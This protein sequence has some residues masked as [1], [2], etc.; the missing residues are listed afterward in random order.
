MTTPNG[1]TDPNPANNSA[2]DTSTITF[3]ADLSVTVTDNKQ[4]YTPG[5]NNVYKIVVVNFGPSNVTGASVTDNFPSVFTG[6]TFTAT[7]MGGASG[8]TA[9]GSGNIRDTVT[10]PVGS[11]I[12]YTA[13]GSISPSA[14]GPLSNTATVTVPGGV[15][16]PN[17]ANNSA[18]DTDT[19]Q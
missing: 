9:S 19:Q 12:S 11:R 5:R 15:T 14:R 17:P 18:T 7:Q 16:D 1:V 6:V 2:T 4:G 13:S 3:Q 10:M 8:F